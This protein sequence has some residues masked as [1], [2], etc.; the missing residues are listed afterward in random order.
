MALTRSDLEFYGVDGW[1]RPVFKTADGQFYCSVDQ[2]YQG[3]EIN[4]AVV[5]TVLENISEGFD[6]LYYKGRRADGE[7]DYPVKYSTD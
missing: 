5:E 4:E 2:L 7:P 6:E 3:N 1:D